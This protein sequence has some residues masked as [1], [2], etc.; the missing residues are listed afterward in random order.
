MGINCVR[1]RQRQIVLCRIRRHCVKHVAQRCDRAAVYNYVQG[2]VDAAVPALG[3]GAG[4]NAATVYDQPAVGVN[5]VALGTETGVYVKLASVDGSYRHVVLIGID[6]VIL[7][8]YVYGSAVYGQMHFCAKALV[9]GY[10][11]QHAR[12]IGLAVNIH[13]HLAV[14]RAV[15]FVQFVGGAGFI[16]SCDI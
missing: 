14:K 16:Y 9:L 3:V 8:L 6:A 15:I 4:K 10:Y 12:T 11:I 5:A 7:G 1:E 2:C 13:R